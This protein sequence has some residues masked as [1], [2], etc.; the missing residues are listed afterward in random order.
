MYD[1]RSFTMEKRTLGSNGLEVSA[2]GL[3]CMSM[4]GGYS[5]RPDRQ[6]MISLIRAAMDRGVTFFDTAEIYGPYANEELEDAASKIQVQGGRY[7]EAAEPMTN[8]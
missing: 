6:E 5:D 2:V 8:L 7:S 3:G 4:T 1:D